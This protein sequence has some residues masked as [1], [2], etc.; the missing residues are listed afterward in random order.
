MPLYV[1]DDSF[2]PLKV[3]E[4]VRRMDAMVKIR[5]ELPEDALAFAPTSAAICPD[6]THGMIRCV[7]LD[8]KKWVNKLINVKGGGCLQEEAIHQLEKNISERDVKRTYF[9]FNLTGKGEGKRCLQISLSG[10]EAAA[11]LADANELQG[12][13]T[14][15]GKLFEGV[16]NEKE[17]LTGSNNTN[18][19]WVKVLR[20]LHPHL[21][22]QSLEGVSDSMMLMADA[23]EL[24]R[25][26]L[27][28]MVR[29][30]RSFKYTSE[31]ICEYM[32]WA[33]T[34]Y[35]ISLT[36]FP[37][38]QALSLYKLKLCLMSSLMNEPEAFR[39]PWDHMTESLE[40]SNHRSQK[41]FQSK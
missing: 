14:Q 3:G 21:F 25:A 2:T 17:L 15:I 1:S 12:T 23:W 11:I 29:A 33:E 10:L 37:E 31:K 18:L 27:H 30:A 26:S 5:Q 28:G 35:Q 8:L 22:V 39:K 13:G 40:K 36:V 32:S 24:W 9:S 4:T 16:W 20:E 34:Y 38:N 41:D 6:V 7:E 19:N